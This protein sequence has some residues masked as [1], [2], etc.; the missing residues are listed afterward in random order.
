VKPRSAKA[1]GTK[2]EKWVASMLEGL[3][4]SARRQPGSGIYRDF[5]HD[6]Q[7]NLNGNRFI[8]ECK[9]RKEP[10]KVLD[11][12][13]GGANVLVVKADRAE[14]RVY[15]P[16][17]M[18]AHLVHEARKEPPPSANYHHGDDNNACG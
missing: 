1:K 13:L 11:G 17:S 10:P 15:M 9:A 5:P 2:L 4:V 12:W 6:V 16:W 18:F 14:P 7:M 8:V 3:G